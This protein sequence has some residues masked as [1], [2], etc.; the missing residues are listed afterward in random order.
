MQRRSLWRKGEETRYCRFMP[1]H[2]TSV[3]RSS[4][5]RL[6]VASTFVAGEVILVSGHG[7]DGETALVWQHVLSVAVGASGG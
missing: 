2:G 5:S 7:M 4:E 1:T 3:V 6:S